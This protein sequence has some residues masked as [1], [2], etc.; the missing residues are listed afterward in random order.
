MKSTL[1]IDIENDET[2][3]KMQAPSVIAPSVIGSQLALT[4]LE[5]DDFSDKRRDPPKSD[6]IYRIGP[7]PREDTNGGTESS[8]IGTLDSELEDK[9]GFKIAAA[10]RAL[11]IYFSKMARK[12]STERIDYRFLDSLFKGGADVNVTDKHGQ[13]V[14]HEVARNWNTDVAKYFLGRGADINKGDKWGRTALHLCSAVN[15]V[16]MIEYLLNNGGN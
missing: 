10:S 3:L 11:I 12:G 5:W 8:P 2:K 4:D 1:V 14:L 6:C 15:H 9:K 7:A 16:E 13:T